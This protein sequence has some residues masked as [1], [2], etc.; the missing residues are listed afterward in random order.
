MMLD[1]I[2]NEFN[3]NPTKIVVTDTASG[4]TF[5]KAFKEFG[6]WIHNLQ[7]IDLEDEEDEL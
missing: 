1:E 4:F 3:L 6:V 2:H 5:V 7:S